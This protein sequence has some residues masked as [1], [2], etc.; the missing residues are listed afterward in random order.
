MSLLTYIA[1][2]ILG[3]RYAAVIAII[4]GILEII[5]LIGPWSAAG[6]AMSV[7]LFQASAPFGWPTWVL[8]LVVGATY[9]V[10]RMF[11]DN[12]I[13]PF[14]VGHAVNLHPVIVLFAILAGGA[15]GGPFGLLVAIPVAATVRLLLRYLY[16]KLVDAPD[17]PPLDEP[18]PRLVERVVQR[19]LPGPP[20]PPV[21]A[22]PPRGAE[23]PVHVE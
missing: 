23:E 12:F 21:R 1:L 10:L 16:R 20:L 7:A 9:F 5:P 15:L 18:P 6:I 4:S 11:E 2:T 22:A 14:V 3:V 8:A 13:I 19:E 17:L